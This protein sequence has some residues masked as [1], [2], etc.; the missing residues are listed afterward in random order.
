MLLVARGR[1]A[2]RRAATAV[3]GSVAL[4]ANLAKEADVT[5]LFVQVRKESPRLD[6]L[7]NSAGVFTFKPFVRTTPADWQKNLGANLT[8]LFLV[9][10]AALPLLQRAPA[11]QIVNIL[12][13]ASRTAFP[14]CSAYAASKFGALGFTR[15]L[16]AELPAIRVTAV[17]PGTT[18]T[19][20]A[21]EFDFP[22]D[23]STLLQPEDIANAVLGV[24][25]QPARA[26]VNEIV[27]MPSHG[28]VGGRK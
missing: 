9:T 21:N 2:L 13:I 12:S 26:T 25:L 3:P 1:A 15:V 24:L 10:R 17:L 6:A 20:M 19:R 4:A 14:K 7:I 18:D 22:V 11:P 27:V 23:R 28:T 5:R 16:A 8:S